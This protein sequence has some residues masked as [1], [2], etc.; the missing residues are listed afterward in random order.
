MSLWTA[1]EAADATGGRAHG[2]WRAGGVAIDSR[3]VAP[4]D[5]FV[6]VV[7]P[8][9]DGHRFVGEAMAGGAAAAVVSRP[10]DHGI[11][12]LEVADTREALLRLAEAARARTKARIAAVTGSVGKT[13]SKEALAHLLA[14]SGPVHASRGNLNNEWGAPLSLARMPAGSAFGVMELGMNHPGEILPLSRLVRPHVALVT[15]IAPAHTAFFPDLAG[16]ADAKAEIF[17]GLEPGGI[18]VINADAPHADRLASAAGGR[19]VRRFSRYDRTADAVLVSERLDAE[20][21]DVE[22]DLRGRRAAFRIGVPGAHWIG[23][24]LGVLLA[25]DALGADPD[26]GA[27]AEV[28]APAGRGARRC[29]GGIRLIDESYNASPAAMRAAFAVLGLHRPDPGG[30]RIAVLGDM[31]ELGDDSDSAHGELVAPLRQAG[32]DTVFAAG[33]GMR[34]LFD[35]LP[36]CIRGGYMRDTACLAPLVAESVTPGDIVLVKGSLGMGMRRI[37]DAI[38]RRAGGNG[39]GSCSTIS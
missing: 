21:S 11:P 12:R 14:R 17:A 3:S 27:F 13:G 34:N 29:L 8:R 20:G 38:E 1:K 16:I 30:R 25:A 28:R 9:N 19:E 22:V 35:R 37:I 31:L 32:V 10:V 33:S 18:A 24:V 26:P 5:L 39:G 7:G 15:A 23:N 6:A 2:G 4:G 36:A